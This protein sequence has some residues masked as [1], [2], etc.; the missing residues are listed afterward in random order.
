MG[1]WAIHSKGDAMN[2]KRRPDVNRILKEGKQA[3]EAIA[4]AAREAVLR[5]VRAGNRVAVGQN[6]EIRL[7]SPREIKLKMDEGTGQFGLL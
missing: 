3:D 2:K 4:R 1:D 5:H 6:G 7:L